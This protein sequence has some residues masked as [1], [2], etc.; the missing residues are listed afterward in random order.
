MKLANLFICIGAQKAG[1]SWLY[2]VLAGDN[3]LQMPMFLKEV[4]FFDYVHGNAV[5]INRWRAT[6]L[7]RLAK[8]K[9]FK[10]VL[11]AYLHHGAAHVF[12][13]RELRP[14]FHQ[15]SLCLRRLDDSWYV[16]YL[17][18]DGSKVFSVDITPCYAVVDREG[19][20][21]MARVSDNLKLL[22]ILRD[23]VDRIRSAIIQDVKNRS[24][25]EEQ[26]HKLVR[27]SAVELKRRADSRHIR[28]RSDYLATLR[29]IAGAGLMDHLK[30]VFYSDIVSAPVDV[31]DDVYAHMGLERHEDVDSAIGRFVHRSPSV[32][33]AEDFFD[34]M[35]P[36]YAPMLAAIDRE[37]VRLP[38]EWKQ[39]YGI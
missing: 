7:R 35:R 33:I 3:R 29:E 12:P 26:M 17:R 31:I 32:R 9:R 13:N 6:W 34:V 24:D 11:A 1:T 15:V 5:L 30:I 36:M 28:R 14:L 39:R 20:A 10:D 25:A 4:H 23:P 21:H 2:S 19:F 22:F 37:Y 16:D 38:N 8:E 18:C 27:E